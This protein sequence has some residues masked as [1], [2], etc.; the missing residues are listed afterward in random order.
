MG[1]KFYLEV[2]GTPNRYFALFNSFELF[3]LRGGR[4]EK[5]EIVEAMLIAPVTFVEFTRHIFYFLGVHI[6]VNV[7]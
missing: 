4:E 5:T 1:L 2:V 3:A 6:L 7:I